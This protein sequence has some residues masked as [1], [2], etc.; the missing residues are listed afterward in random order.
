[1][2]NALNVRFMLPV[3]CCGVFVAQAQAFELEHG[4]P[5]PAYAQ[6]QQKVKAINLTGDGAQAFLAYM[7]LTYASG[8][9]NKI[10]EGQLTTYATV[11]KGLSACLNP[12]ARMSESERF[13]LCREAADSAK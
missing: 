4:L 5:A 1:M 13:K 3:L 10:T 12:D 2:S 8:L 9:S 6:L 11:V 7:Q